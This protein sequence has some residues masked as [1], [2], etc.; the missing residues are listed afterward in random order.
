M[1]VSHPTINYDQPIV[2]MTNLAF[3][4]L[5]THDVVFLNEANTLLDRDSLQC[6]SRNSPLYM[7]IMAVDIPQIL[8]TLHRSAT[9]A[10]ASKGAG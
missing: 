5:N 4:R 8:E 9:I 3:Y 2:H 7:Q 1:I 10:L 6:C